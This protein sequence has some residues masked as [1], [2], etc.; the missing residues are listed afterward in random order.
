MANIIKI[1]CNIFDING[2]DA[3]CNAVNCKG[4]MGGGIAAQFA[5]KYPAMLTDYKKACTNGTLTKG[6]V[7]TFGVNP[8]IINVPTMEFP[9]SNAEIDWLIS[10]IISTIN[11]AK[12]KEFH[13]IALPY[14]GCGVGG[15][16][17]KVF[18]EIFTS[19]V[20]AVYYYKAASNDITFIL[21]DYAGE[22]KKEIEPLKLTSHDVVLDVIKD[23][24]KKISST[25]SKVNKLIDRP[26]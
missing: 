15:F 18:E 1:K 20:K 12:E 2:V 13:T 8:T 14:F 21:V 6:Q 19:I 4:V 7:H 26:F 16:S 23:T 25:K 9:G 5:E 10:A 24:K 22:P 17:K 3:I 11:C